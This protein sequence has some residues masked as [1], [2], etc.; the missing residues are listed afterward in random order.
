MKVQ[1]SRKFW[2][3]LLSI[4]LILFQLYL[5]GIIAFSLRGGNYEEAIAWGVF[6]G[7]FWI[8]VTENG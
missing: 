2:S 8:G 6:M 3:A 4:V 1:K 5:V 7:C